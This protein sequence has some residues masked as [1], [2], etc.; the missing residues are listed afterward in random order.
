MFINCPY[1]SALVATD[2]IT[3]LPPTHCPQCKSLLRRDDTVDDDDSALAP[4]DL[5]DLLEPS[6]A[7]TAQ[8]AMHDTVHADIRLDTDDMTGQITN[9]IANDIQANLLPDDD[10]ID[11]TSSDDT[12]D[13]APAAPSVAAVAAPV[14][15]KQR[16][17][18]APSFVRGVQSKPAGSRERW[19]PAVAATLALLLGLQCVLADRARLAA[20]PQWRPVLSEIGRAHV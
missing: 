13:I 11:N 4:I 17:R 18:N 12:A 2:P 5:G 6:T 10:A 14:P 15:P 8:A 9:D 3:D 16:V 7:E 20:E 19:L 1:C